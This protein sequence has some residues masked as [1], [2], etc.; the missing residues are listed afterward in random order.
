MASS[1]W[2]STT[3]LETIPLDTT[4]FHG[5]SRSASLF[6]LY[7]PETTFSSPMAPARSASSNPTRRHEWPLP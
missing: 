6:P 2:P 3:A 4:A 1:S 5:R 7:G